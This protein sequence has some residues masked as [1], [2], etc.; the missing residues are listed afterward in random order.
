MHAHLW[1]LSCVFSLIYFYFACYF[2]WQHNTTCIFFLLK[3]SKL[4]INQFKINMIRSKLN[5]IN[6][7]GV[8]LY[9]LHETA[10]FLH[11]TAVY[12]YILPLYRLHTLVL[13]LFFLNIIIATVFPIYNYRCISYTLPQDCFQ[14]VSQ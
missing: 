1:I 6:Q 2:P 4:M 3:Y 14:S 5:I 9:F 13:P 12:L 11:I 7:P 8:K 10:V